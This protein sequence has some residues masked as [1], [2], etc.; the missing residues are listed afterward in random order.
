M[1]FLDRLLRGRKGESVTKPDKPN[2][3]T[4]TPLATSDKIAPNGFP[5]DEVKAVTGPLTPEQQAA[6]WMQPMALF[7]LGLGTADVLTIGEGGIKAS[8]V[9]P[10][11]AKWAE[12]IVDM[13]VK[14]DKLA[15]LGRHSEAID[16]Y[17]RVLDKAPQA[18]I[19]LMSIG[20]CYDSLG[21]RTEALK[22]MQLARSADP[23]SERIAK[24]LRILESQSPVG[25]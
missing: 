18:A 11:V 6:L 10:E 15:K 19:A 23:G 13:I 3:P 17:K 14:A 4:R 20:S 5:P 16:A 1:G 25:E 7:A 21:D 8:A 9:S 2:V 12:P 22:W 24:N